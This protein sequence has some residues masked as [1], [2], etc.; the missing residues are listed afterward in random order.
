MRHR[1]KRAFIVASVTACVLV[2]PVV[3]PAQD[4]LPP[5][6]AD[7]MTAEQKKAVADFKAARAVLSFRCCAALR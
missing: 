5:I 3:A 1:E 7:K 4:R 2:W 6:P